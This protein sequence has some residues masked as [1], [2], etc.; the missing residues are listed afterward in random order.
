MVIGLPAL[1][2]IRTANGLTQI[3]LAALISVTVQTIANYENGR[4]DPTLSTLFK[5]AE[6]LKVPVSSLLEGK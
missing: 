1:S 5:L 2:R 6:V 4:A 3:Q